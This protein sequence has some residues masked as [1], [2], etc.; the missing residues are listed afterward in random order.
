[1]RAIAACLLL[2]LVLAPA[3][4]ADDYAAILRSYQSGDA[5]AAVARLVALDYQAIE[6]GFSALV[7]SA[8]GELVSVSAAAAMHTEVALRAGLDVTTARATQ[9]LDMATRLI[10]VG[11]PANVNKNG[12][13]ILSE[14]RIQPV[15]PAFRR[16]WYV[17][18]S[19]VLEA[20]GRVEKADAYLESARALF[21]D[22]EV[23][24]LS[25]VE[26]EMRASGR[27]SATNAGER[28]KALGRAEAFLRASLA[29][30]PAHMESKLRLGRVL[31]L[32][33]AVPDSRELLTAVSAA[34]DKRLG[35]LASL[36]LGGLEDTAGNPTAA[37]E[38]YQRASKRAPSAQSALLAASELRHR[39]GDRLAAAAA[40][41]TAAGAANAA[42]PWWSYLFGEYWQA[43]PRLDALRAMGRT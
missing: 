18:V 1:M 8:D 41:P 32:R 37:A 33:V 15:S 2:T 4:G 31:Q 36:F 19:T 40:I 34:D 14:S 10:E 20:D 6:A 30:D 16:L 38:W 28:R 9:N 35:Y 21:P 5:D 39:A 26:E 27:V 43:D 42:D 24:L 25:G 11:Q 22:G 13:G 17:A 23:L 3:S 12:S 29:Q 7:T